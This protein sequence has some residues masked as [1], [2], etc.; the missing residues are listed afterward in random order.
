MP[1]KSRGPTARPGLP[2][3]PRRTGLAAFALLAGVVLA[4]LALVLAQNI[5]RG[6]RHA[7][8]GGGRCPSAPG[9]AQDAGYCANTF[10]TNHNFTTATVDFLYT[11]RP[12]FQWYGINFF[13]V[14]V[15]SN[16]Q[17]LLNSDGSASEKATEPGDQGF[18]SVGVSP[19]GGM[20]GTA[21][22][23]GMYVEYTASY[24]QRLVDP[25]L[26]WPSLWT[27][28]LEHIL[29][30]D[31]WPVPAA[32]S[33]NYHEWAEF[34]ILEHE[35]RGATNQ[36][37]ATL[38]HGYG[39]ARTTCPGQEWCDTQTITP[40]AL[41]TTT[42][43]HRYGML[44]AP[45]TATRRGYVKWFLDG[46]QQGATLNWTHEDPTTDAPPP[47]LSTPWTYGVVDRQHLAL[48]FGSGV[49]APITVY[50]VEVWQ[51]DASH[52]LHK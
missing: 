32:P 36:Y 29:N 49:N 34:D 18:A 13:G 17:L 5:V 46:V 38:H 14:Y 1:K 35:G 7:A 10:S 23:G 12:G 30:T 50:D 40:I 19:S 6:G 39:V 51:V 25:A 15:G 37:H 41:S 31:L 33:A 9:P 47:T 21:F 27:F 3:L 42:T 20:V 44:W 2:P 48:I 4:V 45:A 43:P 11:Y 26:G 22:G 16:N 52:N 24:D 28:S 8:G